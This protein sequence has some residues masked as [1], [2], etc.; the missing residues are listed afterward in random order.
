MGLGKS[1]SMA[2]SS[3]VNNK[4]RA[5]LTMLGIIIGI[6]AVIILVSVMDGLTGMITNTFEEMG[7]E[8]ITVSI[9]SRATTKK[10]EPDE[11]YEFVS[12]NPDL[13]SASSP[14]VTLG[15]TA[16]TSSSGDDSITVS[17]Q[18]VGEDYADM[19]SL[20]LSFG[21]FIQF[22]DCD[23]EEKVCV[24]GSYEARYFFGS[25]SA[26]VDKI[27][28]IN[29]D[30]YRI[31]GILEEQEDSSQ[32]SA[33]DCVYIP[34]T[35]A[36]KASGSTTVTSYTLTAANKDVVTDAVNKVKQFL[37]QKIGDEDYYNVISMLSMIEQMEEIMGTMSMVLVAIAGISLL[38]GGIGIMNIMLVSVTERTREIG[39][40][41]SLGAKQKDIMLQF[42]I[43]AGTVSCIGGIIGIIIGSIVSMLAGKLLDLTVS[44]SAWAIVIAFGVSVGIGIAFGF[45]PAKKA[46]KLNPI[47]ALRYE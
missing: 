8:T 14:V 33:D 5:F 25:A 22:I 2:I 15:G 24:I 47:D 1:F 37:L 44:P 17:A 7:T 30:Q 28:K 27:L 41:K 35:T 26:A 9:M 11:M 43:E 40:R 19:K 42:V 6:A 29:G 38:V 46:A 32:S 23:R 4:V 36:A 39:I 31:V 3:I 12:E 21:R 13:L 16:K 34:Y 45:L 20:E 10:V 18:G